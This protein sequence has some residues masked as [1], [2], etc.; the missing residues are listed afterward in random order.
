MMLLRVIFS[1]GNE[2]GLPL[3]EGLIRSKIIYANL[4]RTALYAAPPERVRWY[5]AFSFAPLV[6]KHNEGKYSMFSNQCQGFHT[7]FFCVSKQFFYI[8][9]TDYF[10]ITSSIGV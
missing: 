7:R 2:K 1:A 5:L 8:L 9:I 3:S 6:G 10:N 4:V